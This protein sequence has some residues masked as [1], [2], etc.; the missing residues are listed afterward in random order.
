[1]NDTDIML[2]IMFD[3]GEYICPCRKVNEYKCPIEINTV[4]VNNYIRSD[5]DQWIAANPF[6]PY[7]TRRI[8]NLSSLRN[9]VIEIDRADMTYEDQWD[10]I[11]SFHTPVSLC[12]FSGNKSYHFI[13]SLE[14]GVSLKEYRHICNKI[15]YNMDLIDPACMEPSTFTRLAGSKRE[16]V[17]QELKYYTKRRNNKEFYEWLNLLKDKPTHEKKEVSSTKG[18]SEMTR[19]FIKFGIKKG[20]TSRHDK[21]KYMCIDLFRSGF[22]IDTA[23]N[24]VTPALVEFNPD[25]TSDEVEKMLDW[26]YNQSDLGTAHE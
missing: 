15:K 23:F 20:K 24:I 7:T 21:L 3:E 13:I 18:L 14:E 5:K 4:K 12:T 1:M 19:A 17:V 10:Y 25:K 16:E 11:R 6:K 9:F 22:D 26:V 2:R 8:D